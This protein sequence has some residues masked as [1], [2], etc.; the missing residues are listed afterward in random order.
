M[1]WD[2]DKAFPEEEKGSCN[3]VGEEG[4]GVELKCTSQGG[5]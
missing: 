2:Q 5:E 4:V 1:G 3:E